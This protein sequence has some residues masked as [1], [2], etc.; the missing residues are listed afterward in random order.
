MYACV[1]MIMIVYWKKPIVCQIGRS[2]NCFCVTVLPLPSFFSSLSFSETLS[3]PFR[4][5]VESPTCFCIIKNSPDRTLCCCQ[6]FFFFARSRR[7]N[8][9]VDPPVLG[10]QCVLDRS[11]WRWNPTRGA[12]AQHTA[13]GSSL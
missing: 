12:R 3:F 2:Q 9:R 6:H 11:G 7:R 4:K 13:P 10:Q 1:F 5:T 8:R